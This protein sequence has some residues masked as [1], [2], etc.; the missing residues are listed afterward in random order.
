MKQKLKM[1]Q[2]SLTCMFF[3]LGMAEIQAQNIIH[4]IE[5]RD[6]YLMGQTYRQ[7]RNLAFDITYEYGDS[8]SPAIL[9][10]LNSN[11]RFRDG[12]MHA[13]IDSTEYIVGDKFCVAVYHEDSFVA[14]SKKPDIPD[15]FKLPLTD[16][17][18]LK[19]QV[20]SITSSL[21]NDSTK[22]IN[23][24]FLPQSMY[25]G[26]TVDFDIRKYII[27]NIQVFIKQPVSPSDPGSGV[28]R[29]VMKF[30]NYNSGIIQ[31]SE[32]DEYRFIEYRNGSIQLRQEYSNYQL[33]FNA[34]K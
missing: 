34:D 4:S 30:S 8:A 2:L 22:R 28:T 15:V 3:I 31:D 12:R 11:Y 24:S 5:T 18:F 7:A 19:S 6:F 16:S 21:L 14:V 13:I 26:Y 10:S 9:E 20:N 27:R 23:L 1:K 17:I 25:S 32:F 33:L 29:I